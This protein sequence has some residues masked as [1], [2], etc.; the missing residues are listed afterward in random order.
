MKALQKFEQFWA[1]GVVKRI[2]P[3]R[4]RAMSLV[5]E[6]ER[7]MLSLREK[8]EKLGLKDENA[9]DYVEYCYD[10]I[11]PLVRAK[12]YLEGYSATGQGAHEAEVSYLRLL[13]FSEKEVHFL[14]EL[15]FFRNGILYYGNSFD[16]E[17]AKKVVDFTKKIFPKLKEIAKG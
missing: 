2:T 11:M 15:R 10:T 8:L 12:L 6:S 5:A 7:R 14:D 17:Y 4:G 16:A 13:G 3:N 9:N 1:E